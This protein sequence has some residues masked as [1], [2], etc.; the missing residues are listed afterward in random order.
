MCS[1]SGL[2]DVGGASLWYEQAGEGEPLVLLHGFT[3]DA[4]LWDSLFGALAEHF[5]AIRYDLRGHGRSSLPVQ[6]RP[7]SHVADLEGLLDAL[8]I[9]RAALCGSSMGGGVALDF[10]L[11][12]ADAVSRLALV[13]STLGGYRW[14]DESSDLQRAVYR[15]ARESGVEA[16]RDLWMRNPLFALPSGRPGPNEL[17]SSMLSAYSGWHW[18]NRDPHVAVKPPAASRLGEIHVP[19]LVLVGELDIPDMQGIASALASGIPGARKAVIK[20]A[21]HLTPIEVPQ[22][23]AELVMAFLSGREGEGESG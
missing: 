19:T 14:T 8:G 20:G 21:G 17:L 22:E 9:H 2:L 23:V 13:D 12:H 11:A 10:A 7:Y 5:R 16:A 6:D 3:L 15:V 4:R 1:V 18:L